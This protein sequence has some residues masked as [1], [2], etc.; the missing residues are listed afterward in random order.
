M[1]MRLDTSSPYLS[2]IPH[3]GKLKVMLCGQTVIGDDPMPLNV[4]NSL[5]LYLRIALRS[6]G[7]GYQSKRRDHMK[8]Y[9]F[10]EATPLLYFIEKNQDKIIGT[11]LKNLY[12]NIWPRHGRCDILEDPI[13]LDFDCFLIAIDYLVPSNM[14]ITI[15]SRE[16]MMGINRIADVLSIKDRRIDY[17]SE[18][19]Y[20]P[21]FFNPIKKEEIENCKV[22]KIDVERFSSAFEC[23]P[24]TEEIRPEGGDYFSTIRIY[25]DSGLALCFCGA[26]SILDGYIEVWCE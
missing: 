23:D 19:D 2:G 26:D 10:I 5:V 18:N 9:N 25:L 8:E 11:H 24:C 3:D 13:V 4:D 6:R 21:G 20:Y 7:I 16:E 14:D 15:G 22:V 1:K 17:Y 12:I